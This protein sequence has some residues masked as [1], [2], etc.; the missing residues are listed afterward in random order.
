MGAVGVT[1]RATAAA[2]ADARCYTCGSFKEVMR[3]VV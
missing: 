3:L 2:P 1:V